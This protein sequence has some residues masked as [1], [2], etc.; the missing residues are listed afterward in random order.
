MKNDG[1]VRISLTKTPHNPPRRGGPTLW[2]RKKKDRNAPSNQS[3]AVKK[4]GRRDMFPMEELRFTRRVK[5]VGQPFGDSL[6]TGEEG[7]GQ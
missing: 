6:E 7:E 5:A 2:G 1:E 4:D 3:T